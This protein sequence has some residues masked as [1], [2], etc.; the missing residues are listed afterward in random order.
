MLRG[1]PSSWMVDAVI[2]QP[3]LDM[4]SEKGWE[5]FPRILQSCPISSSLLQGGIPSAQPSQQISEQIPHTAAHNF[6]L[7]Y[8]PPRVSFILAI[9][10]KQLQ[11]KTP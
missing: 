2:S 7:G 8:T 6:C 1:N 11:S 9:Q 5:G 3:Y 4:N 10:Q